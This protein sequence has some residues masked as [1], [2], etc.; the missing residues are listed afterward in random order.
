MKTKFSKIKT[1]IEENPHLTNREL[2]EKVGKSISWVKAFKAFMR[3]PDKEKYANT[4]NGIY[5]A[6][7]N[8]WKEDIEAQIEE[9]CCEENYKLKEELLTKNKMLSRYKT[10]LKEYDILLIQLNKEKKDLINT[11]NNKVKELA[12]AICK[13]KIEKL[14]EQNKKLEDFIKELEEEGD[15]LVKELYTKKASLYFVGFFSGIMLSI[16]VY[17]FLK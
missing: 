10:Q 15:K 8:S 13:A 6:I 4:K 14:Q 2:A 9:E 1:I 7:Y 11:L 12:Q 16:I 3:A 17:F 5:R